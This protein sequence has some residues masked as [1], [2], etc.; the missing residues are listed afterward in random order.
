M[1]HLRSLLALALAGAL[2]AGG[3]NA[4]GLFQS[5]ARGN[6][7]V[8]EEEYALIEKY[9]RLEEIQEIVDLMYLWEYSAD[10]L[11]EG[12]ARGML[13]ALGDDYTFYYTPDQ[14]VQENEALSGEYGGLGIEVFPNAKDDTI[15]I[16][17][18][19]YGGPSQEAGL[20]PSDKILRINGEDISAGDIND[21]VDIMRGEIGGEVSLTILREQE[22]FDVTM[23]RAL[24]QTEIVEYEMLE[25][26]IGYMRVFYFEGNLMGQ[27]A[28]ARA[29]FEKEGATGLIIDLRENPGGLV[30]LAIEMADEFLG[31]DQL[32]LMTED[33][34]GRQM[35]FYGTDGVWD[36]PL[37]VLVDSY[38]ASASEI[39]AAAMQ[40]NEIGKVVGVQTFGKGIM[41]SVY[42]FGG[43]GAGM[44]ITSDYWLTPDGNNLHENGVT[45]DVEVE[46]AED[47][48]DENYR[49]IREKDNQL[50]AAVETLRTLIAS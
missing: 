35:S 9:Q 11:L 14:M 40:E 44:Q 12:A 36:I 3:A 42:P 30:N 39:I 45:P 22:V 37:V 41:Q 26:G 6:I 38:S 25:G 17:R 19:F 43:D 28:D 46:L 20:R 50:E 5:D 33:K 31:K 10:E 21:A 23:K 27:F 49:F 18:V 4:L 32:V 13:G 1:K 47:A 2:I 24:V 34:Y 29:M 48:I 7:T 8:T 16:K 15:T